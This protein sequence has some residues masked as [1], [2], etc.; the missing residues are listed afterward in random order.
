M[1]R[2]ERTRND[3]QTAS[4]ISEANFRNVDVVNQNSARSGFSESEQ[5]QGKCA[6]ARSGPTKDTNLASTY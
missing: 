4:E 2:S 6:F 3:R 5:G 1:R